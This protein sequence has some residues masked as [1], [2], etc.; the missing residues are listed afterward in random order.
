MYFCNFKSGVQ[1]IYDY[2]LSLGVPKEKIAVIMSEDAQDKFE[3]SSGDAGQDDVIAKINS[4]AKEMLENESKLPDNIQILISTSRL[5]EGVN[6]KNKDFSA[7]VC[8]SHYLPDII[9]Y[10]GRVRKEVML[11]YIDVDTRIHNVV[12][13][14]TEY[15]FYA[16]SNV[17]NACNQHLSSLSTWDEKEKYINFL[18]NTSEYIAYDFITQTF[19]AKS[20]RFEYEQQLIKSYPTWFNDVEDFINKFPDHYFDNKY[21]KDYIENKNQGI[22]YINSI[23]GKEIYDDAEKQKVYDSLKNVFGIKIK[24][25]DKL[26]EYLLFNSDKNWIVKTGLRGKGKYRGKMGFVI[27]EHDPNDIDWLEKFK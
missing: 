17:L 10:M 23:L 20:I 2:C 15:N 16:D 14:E 9:Q 21:I 25:P 13:K 8:E 26:N 7:I 4:A 19:Y 27:K 12:C 22:T 1:S 5:R 11:L 6:I 24:Q 3:N 18:K